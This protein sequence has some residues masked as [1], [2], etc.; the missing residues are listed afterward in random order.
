MFSKLV[1]LLWLAKATLMLF[2]RF[3]SA[4]SVTCC[5]DGHP[6]L[7][8]INYRGVDVKKILRI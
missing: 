7:R 3:P 4:P 5:V 6:S 8:R 2:C 1:I